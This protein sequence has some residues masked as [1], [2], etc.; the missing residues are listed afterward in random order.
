MG[1]TGL[2]H[3]ALRVPDVTTAKDFYTDFG[4]VAKDQDDRVD[5]RCDGRA[6]DQLQ[7]FEGPRKHF[8]HVAFAIEPGSQD[9]FQ[10]RAERAGVQLLDPPPG[11]RA[12]GLW[13]TD[14]DGR[15][16]NLIED[17]PAAAREVDPP[18]LNMAG[19]YQRQDVARWQ[20]LLDE[21]AVPRRLG[22]S[23]V[24]TPDLAATERFYLD[25]VGLGLSDRIKGRISFCNAG[26]GDHH[27]FGFIQST[28]PGF[29]HASFEMDGFDQVGMG[30]QQMAARG[31]TEAWGMGRHTLG[32]NVFYYV[33]DPWG[34]WVEYFTDI[35]QITCAWQPEEWDVPPKTWSPALHPQFL[36]NQEDFT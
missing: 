6:Q 21:V 11:A 17:V 22:H 33:Q 24:F 20:L 26:P 27:V 36:L 2:L 19:S 3:I 8:Q 14:P 31:H 16:V 25:V 18:D 15:Y 13:F 28:H 12:E 10:T 29:H 4:L 34:S 35:D 1:P 32:S 9:A 5:L 30:G 7:I 23:L